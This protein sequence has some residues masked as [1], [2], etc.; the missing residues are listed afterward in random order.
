M[1]YNKT[2]RNNLIELLPKIYFLCD[3]LLLKINCENGINIHN[4]LAYL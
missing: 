3:M 2:L 1:K 4:W